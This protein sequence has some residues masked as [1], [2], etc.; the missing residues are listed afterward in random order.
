MI[1]YT[2]D[3][4]ETDEFEM[5][6]TARPPGNSSQAL[7]RFGGQE[8]VAL[9]DSGATCSALP[10]EVAVAI[11]SH[12]LR[13]V[14]KGVYTQESPKYPVVRVQRFVRRPR[15]DGVAAKAPI[16]VRYALVLNA[17][18]VPVEAH[19]GPTKAMYF[20]VFPKGMC[21]VPGVIVGFP[22]LDCEP[23]GLGWV[24]HPTVH[25]FRSLQ[26]SL[27]RLE[28]VRR[29]E[30]RAASRSYYEGLLAE[31]QQADRANVMNLCH[32]SRKSFPMKPVAVV[33]AEDVSLAPGERAIVP[34]RWDRG[35]PKEDFWCDTSKWR[36]VSV[37]PGVCPGGQQ[38]MQLCVCNTA[39]VD[40]VLTRGEPLAEA[41]DWVVQPEKEA[42]KDSVARLS[43]DQENEMAPQQATMGAVIP[44]SDATARELAPLVAVAFGTTGQETPD[45][46]PRCLG[47]VASEERRVKRSSSFSH[48]GSPPKGQ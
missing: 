28:L 38:Q 40:V 23:Y 30:Y 5:K 41:C 25:T 10:E 3:D 7:I 1:I 15:I 34:A 39:V 18:F 14:E 32:E 4:V 45:E 19:E 24:V 21:S 11:I 13:Q 26:V 44:L 20:Q 2:L 22:A 29:E 33:D 9:L 16:E 35:I 46:P 6:D 48:L 47:L 31:S 43:R 36:A 27:P 12:A 17:E 8:C 37:E 42:V